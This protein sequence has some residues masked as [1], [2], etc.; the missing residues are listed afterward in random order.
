MVTCLY[1]HA[2]VTNSQEVVQAAWFRQ[3][4]ERVYSALETPA[5]TLRFG[6]QTYAVLCHLGRG[7]SSEVLMAQRV[8]PLPER[9]TVKLSQRAHGD[10]ARALQRAA[11]ALEQLQQSSAQGAPYFTRRLPQVLGCGTVE[12]A[13]ADDRTALLLRYPAGYW[14]SL[15]DVLQAYQSKALAIDPR[16]AVWMGRRVLEVLDFVHDS[17]WVHQ[18]LCPENLLVHPRD[19]GVQIIGW[20]KAEP[21]SAASALRAR[22]LMQV[23]W[24]LRALLSGAADPS[25]GAWPG[26]VPAP[27]VHVLE[28]CEDATW[29]A[30]QGARGLDQALQAAAREAFGAPRFVHFN[31]QP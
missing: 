21:R 27:L 15:A 9:V 2:S 20:S 29:C 25:T 19:H 4:Y 26:H 12:G 5:Q 14:G 7:A 3:A 8:S 30:Q 13:F 22:D 23:A 31:P 11:H 24:S 28:Q 1:C 6:A 10:S 17:G 18:D 16:H